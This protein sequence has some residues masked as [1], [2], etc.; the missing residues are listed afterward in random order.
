MPQEDILAVKREKL[1]T[2]QKEGRDPFQI[3]K[4]DVTH[5]AQEIKDEFESL[6]G[7]TVRVAGR[8]MFKRKMGKA[9]FCNCMDKS[10]KIQI[11]VARDTLGEEAYDEFKKYL[12]VGD[13]IGAEGEVFRT[14]TGEISIHAAKLTLLSKELKPLPEKFHGLTDTDIR[15]R[16]RYVDLIMN[17]DVKETFIKRS[18]IIKEI[19]NFL[20]GRDFIEVET[21][22]LLSNA[23]GAAARP[24]ETHYNALDED[25][26]LRISLELYLKRLI[27]GGLERVYEIGRVFRNEG[28]DTKHNP[29][30]TLMEL[31]QA[32]TDYYGMME[33]TES[34]FRYLAEKVCGSTKFTYGDIELDFGKTFE[35]MTMNE[36]IKKYSD[37][38]FDTIATDEEAKALAKERGIEPLQLSAQYIDKFF[39]DT[40]KLGLNRADIYP[41]ASESMDDIIQMVSEIIDNGFGYVTSDGSVYFSVD[42]VENYGRLTNQKLENMGN[43][44]RQ[45]LNDEEKKNPMDFALWKAAKP[46]EISWDSPWGKGRPGWH[47]ECSAMIRR[48]LGNT[49][50]IHGGGNDLIFPH[51]EN[52]ILQTEA[53]IGTPLANYW[54]HNG[55]LQVKGVGMSK[56]EKMSKS[57]GNFFR[58]EDV[59]KKYDKYTIRFY[60]LNTHYMSPLLYGEDLIQ[61]AN[62]ALKRLWNNYRGLQAYARD[63]SG[64]DD[65]EKLVSDSRDEFKARMDDDFNTRDAIEVL[66]SLARTTNKMMADGTLSKKGAENVIAFIREIDQVLGIMPEDD[67]SDDA[68]DSV[69][70]ILIDIRAE[71]RKR[72]AY[73][74]ADMIRDRLTEAGIQIEDSS[75]GAKWKK[76]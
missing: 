10:G 63:A 14:Q 38:D 27:V 26:K 57:L 52:E 25:V 4:Y 67:A 41:K 71:L 13:I 8:M 15:Y 2:L 32:Y 3:T 62:S 28:M 31:Y 20:D 9:S 11:Y 46:G 39:E 74:L 42:K 68:L 35:R 36:C 65:A 19:R 29:E 58:V 34:M 69:M 22:M 70:G 6:D 45:V 17:E 66:F 40:E 23:G 37:V 53:C 30:F 43:Q 64:S 60:F 49:I 76:I 73:D 55:M 59:A 61:E 75:S 48:H 16:Q 50:D 7:K 44:G 24:F 47:I 18:Q 51:H 21:P 12:D 33:L 54:M 5:H 56:E 72:K 1:A